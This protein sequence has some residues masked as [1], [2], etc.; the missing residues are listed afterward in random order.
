MASGAKLIFVLLLAGV[1][2]FSFKGAK[3]QQGDVDWTQGYSDDIGS[4]FLDLAVASYLGTGDHDE[5][6][7][8]QCF[9]KS[10]GDYNYTTLLVNNQQCDISSKVSCQMYIAY[11]VSK[12]NYVLAFRGTIG[13]EQLWEEITSSLNKYTKYS[14]SNGLDFGFV[15]MYFNNALASLWPHMMKS[16]SNNYNNDTTFYVTGHSLGGAMASITAAKLV[17]DQKILPENVKLVTFGQPR[18]WG[19]SAASQYK[20]VV[21]HSWRVVHNTDPIPHGPPMK[22]GNDKTGDASPYHHPTEIF[23]K[24]KF[25]SHKSCSETDGEDNDCSD[26]IPDFKYVVTALKGEHMHYFNH[27]LD[28]YGMAGCVDSATLLRY[29]LLPVAALVL[30]LPLELP[31]QKR[32][33]YFDCPGSTAS[34]IF[35]VLLFIL[36]VFA[37]ECGSKENQFAPCMQKEK[38]DSLFRNCCETRVPPVCLDACQYESDEV[39]ARANLRQVLRAGCKLTDLTKVLLCAAQNQD[40][41]ECCD[42]LKLSDPTLGVGDRCLR[43]CNPAGTKIDMIEKQDFTCFYNWNVMMYCHHGGIPAENF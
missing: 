16:I 12:N 37:K 31:P 23:Y 22:T 30:R 21:P 6:M 20:N 35:L 29:L 8:Q 4:R 5:A 18:T 7:R 32:G 13:L 36:P 34:M 14:F 25:E 28:S 19:Y 27:K 3:R 1:A 10:W 33:F 42:T 40:N 24:D 38:A 15:N 26:G 11:S 43:F 17:M 9:T 41:R 39:A 2:A